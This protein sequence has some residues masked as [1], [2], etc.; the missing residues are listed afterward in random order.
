MSEVRRPPELVFKTVME[1][2]PHR[3][4]SKENPVRDEFG[5]KF[6]NQINNLGNVFIET[7]FT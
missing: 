1:L 4:F 3:T 2:F 7:C 5:I 6:I